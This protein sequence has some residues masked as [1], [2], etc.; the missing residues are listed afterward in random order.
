MR[1]EKKL[2]ALPVPPCPPLEQRERERSTPYSWR[3]FIRYAAEVYSVDGDEVLTVTTF[4]INGKPCHRFFQL[5]EQCGVE[6]FRRE[7]GY[8]NERR[9]PGRL[10]GAGVDHFYSGI[11][12]WWAYDSRTEFY[13]TEA[14]AR[15]VLDYLGAPDEAPEKAVELLAKRQQEHRKDVIA[16]REEKQREAL[17]R[18]LEGL[19]PGAPEGFVQWCE[20]VPMAG[21]RYFFYRYTGEPEQEGVC[22]YCGEASRVAGIRNHKMGTCP[23]CGSRV[24]FYSMKRFAAGNGIGHTIQAAVC[25]PVNGRVAARLFS[26]GL[27]LEWDEQRGL[28]KRFWSGEMSRSYLDGQTGAERAYYEAPGP[29][30]KVHVDGLCKAVCFGRMG[31]YPVAPFHLRELREHMGLYTP[32]EVLA[33]RGC[34]LDAVRMWWAALEHPKAEYLVKLGLYRLAL[35]E[36]AGNSALREKG[37]TVA[38]LL[39][40]PAEAVQDLRA[41]DPGPGALECIRGL[42]KCGARVTG[43]DM[44]DISELDL[45]WNAMNTLLDMTRFGTLHKALKYVKDQLE[46]TKAFRDGE[47]VLQT[48]RDYKNMALD[49]GKDV[50]D[51]R[52]AL[53]KTLKTAHDEAAKSLRA[54][55][56]RKLN[57]K[58]K[59]SG[60]KLK[61]LCW[62][63]GGLTIRP[64]VSQEE[65]FQEGET[66]DHCVGRAGYAQ[67]MAEFRT[68][69]FFIRREKTPDVPYVTMELD[70]KKWEK[71][72]CY[73]KHDSWPGKAVDEFVKRWI[74]E[75]VKP[76][77]RAK[78]A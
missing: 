64:A 65:L 69:I 15:A 19:A 40:V 50:E 7:D 54:K 12:S 34:E 71:I 11:G 4:D 29:C 30:V 68:A 72:Q 62:S 70:L 49:L 55:K 18:E 78:T 41:A 56:D 43:Q 5:G 8:G 58:V 75:V 25:Q 33:A 73:G 74:E 20:E 17:R 38:Q 23:R 59:R 60:D 10:Y 57:R 76:A 44:R 77:Q 63:F 42:L 39:G 31:S 61:N 3:Y 46:R 9:E 66:L 67:K 53:P 28:Q 2:L 47:H 51:V 52:V 27:R 1:H 35:A 22:S 26:V 14:S 48:W 21:Y 36:L 16:R 6:V 24:E 45:R 32:L 37:K 13:G